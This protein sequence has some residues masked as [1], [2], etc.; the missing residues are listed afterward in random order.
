MNTALT[1]VFTLLGVAV[2]SFLNV[3]IDRLP[4]R[5]SLAFPSSHCDKFQHPLSP[6]DLIPVFSYLWLQGRC[7]YCQARI[8]LRVLV[9][10]LSSGLLFCLAFW[11]YG[12]SAEFAITAFFGSIFVVIMAID[13]EH[14]LILNRVVYPSA[15]IVL[16][17][18]AIDFLLPRRLFPDLLFLPPP[19]I[20]SGVIGGALGF[21]FFLIFYLIKPGG[22]GAGDV[23]LAG[24]IGLVT[25]FPLII[26]ALFIGIVLGGVVAVTLILLKKRGL[27]D[28][29]PYGVFLG[30][31]PIVTLLW[32]SDLLNWYLSLL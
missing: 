21:T 23:K 5:K 10:E 13:W 16:I 4:A 32:G 1:V 15:V 20:L 27:K 12:L 29:I 25:G 3:A 31:G 22:M 30:V 17:I 18:L 8:P 6:G 7:R 28:T 24:L 19:K 9:I 11:R 14:K 2:G 26:V